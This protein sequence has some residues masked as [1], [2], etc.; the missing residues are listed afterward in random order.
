MEKDLRNTDAIKKLKELAE[1]VRVCMYVTRGEEIDARPMSTIK[2]EED[3]SI[4][5][6]TKDNKKVSG[7]IT[8]SEARYWM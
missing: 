6:F 8:P 3:G 7:K 5:F 1:A 2:V 4:W